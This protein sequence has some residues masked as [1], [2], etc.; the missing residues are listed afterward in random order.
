VSGFHI[1]FDETT[2]VPVTADGCVYYVGATS[3]GEFLSID[4]AIAWADK[5]AWG[6]VTWTFLKTREPLDRKEQ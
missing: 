2:P 4:D 3:G 5:Q 1:D 6:P